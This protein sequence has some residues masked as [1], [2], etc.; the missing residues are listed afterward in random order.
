MRDYGYAFEITVCFN[1]E[2]ALVKSYCALNGLVAPPRNLADGRPGGNAV[3][4]SLRIG[5]GDYTV[6]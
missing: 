5:I 6:I 2:N 1:K 3:I 4:G